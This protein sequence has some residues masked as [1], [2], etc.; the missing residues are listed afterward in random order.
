MHNLIDN[1]LK[2]A[3]DAGPIEVRSGR[4]GAFARV[5]VHDHGPGIPPEE[6]ARIFEAFFRGRGRGPGEVSGFGL[7]LSFA[8]DIARAHG[9][10]LTLEPSETGAAFCLRLP[11]RDEPASSQTGAA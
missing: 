4:D 1:A 11:L 10:D 5:L 9:G 2:Y 3:G 6:R 7:G 8:R